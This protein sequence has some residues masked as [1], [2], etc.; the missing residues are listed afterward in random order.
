MIVKQIPVG[1]RLNFCYVLIENSEAIIMDPG[2]EADKILK[3]VKGLKVKAI[4][5]THEH[6]DHRGAVKAIKE[7]THAPVLGHELNP[8]AEQKIEKSMNLG[9]VEIRVFHT[10]GHTPGSISLLVGNKLFTGDT[11]FVEG[12]GRTDLP[13]G[14]QQDIEQSIA[15]LLQLPPDTVVY[16]GHDYGGKSTTINHIKNKHS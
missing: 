15:K 11:L 9:R 8:F 5:L 4:I 1:D 16:P 14:S 12:H 6:S 7:N 13:G 2:F 3:E 10:P